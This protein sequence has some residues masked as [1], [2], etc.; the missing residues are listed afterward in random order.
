MQMH[1]DVNGFTEAAFRAVCEREGTTPE[2]VLEGAVR[3][4][5]GE[6]LHTVASDMDTEERE[7]RERFRT[8]CHDFLKISGAFDVWP[9]TDADE[10]KSFEDAIEAA[11]ADGIETANKMREFNRR[12]RRQAKAATSGRS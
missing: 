4:T 10:P 9:Y 12:A 3:N 1:I 5:I 6:Y 11:K 8:A 2:R 7:H